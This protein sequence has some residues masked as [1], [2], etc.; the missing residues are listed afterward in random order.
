MGCLGPERKVE[1]YGKEQGSQ[2]DGERGSEWNQAELGVTKE[3]FLKG[4]ASG[5]RSISAR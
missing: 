1:R 5:S 3:H 4:D 2:K